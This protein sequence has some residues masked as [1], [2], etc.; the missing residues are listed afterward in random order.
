MVEGH[1][2]PGVDLHVGD[3]ATAHLAARLRRLLALHLVH[4]VAVQHAQRR[5]LSH[6]ENGT[7]D[8]HRDW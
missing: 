4:S 7:G 8:Q 6:A 5:Q 1:E 2:W 3:P